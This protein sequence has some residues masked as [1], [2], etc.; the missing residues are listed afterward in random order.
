MAK[1][2][3][4]I[5]DFEEKIIDSP[6]EKAI[7]DYM[8]PYSEYII[9]ERALPK[10][11]DGLKPV[12]RRILY[13]MKE[14]NM[15]PDGPYKKSARVVG[16]CLGKYHPHGDSSIYSAMVNMVQDFKSRCPLVN[17][18]GNFGSIDNDPPAAMRYTEVKLQP[19]SMELMTDLDKDTVKWVRN[20][21]DTLKEPD[22]LPG[23][24]PNLLV[25][26]A[27]G[28]AIGLA[29]KIPPH[30]LT[31]CLDGAIALINN[32][33]MTTRE[34]LNYVKGPDF[35]TG[36]FVIPVTPL[37][38]IYQTGR[39][40]VIIRAKVDI[41]M[42][43]RD[44]Q[45]I[46]ITELP[47]GAVKSELLAKIQDMQLT[48]ANTKDRK[49]VK[50]ENPLAG[51]QEISDESDS[52]GIRAV[53]TVK[54]GEDAVKIVD[55]LF[56]KKI[57]EDSFNYNVTAIANGKPEVLG[58]VSLLEYF[59]EHQ[60]NVVYKRSKFDCKN[61][62]KRAHI[63]EGFVIVL[64]CID[65]VVT[66]IKNS[67]SRTEAKTKLRERFSLSEAQADAILDLK[68]VNLTRMEV[69]KVENELASLHK[70][71]ASLEKIIASN[72]EQL[73]VVKSEL[74]ELRNKY[75]SKRLS[76][77]VDDVKDIEIKAFDVT[78]AISKRGYVCIDMLGR[79]KM[80]SPR[81]FLSADREEPKTSE[82]IIKSMVFVDK[83]VET[84]II[85]SLGNAY[86]TNFSEITEK[87]WDEVGENL[88]DIFVDAP[89]EERCV[90]IINVTE[91]LDKEVF[92]YT[93]QGMVK[94]SSVKDYIVNKRSYQV[95]VLKDNDEVI[96]VEIVKENSYIMFVSS[97]GM[98]LVSE[99]DDYPKQGRKAGGV[100]GMV[101]SPGAVCV[102]AGQVDTE[103]EEVPG[104]LVLVSGDGYAKRVIASGISV[105]KRARK[106]VKVIDVKSVVT[107]ANWVTNPYN[108]VMIDKNDKVCLSS[109]EEIPIDRNRQGKGKTFV[110]GVES[111][112]GIKFLSDIEK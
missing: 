51:I 106:G 112:V 78:N 99:T 86:K 54:K 95:C 88:S 49:G 14:L 59:V 70:L 69:T 50:V 62:K 82:S 3:K 63:L 9:L 97:D 84:I 35:P 109:T 8:M 45:N 24:F 15:K 104:E 71:I 32:P 25:N 39:G 111:I 11:E 16:D 10:V 100:I 79:L 73:N 7:H 28:I 52:H 75:P 89:K 4:I 90:A 77:M 38:E 12:Q 87:R 22:V 68:L 61:A 66:L 56:K 23:K 58:I 65:E 96:G 107:F 91:N 21:D 81:Q 34:M 17:G 5:E 29:T 43:E 18:H 64:P 47:Y 60:R 76:V 37:E 36:G 48:L 55:F 31:E 27:E 92:I 102:F 53:L 57:L 40:K 44:R 46:V 30:N 42:A 98:S 6:L 67:Q 72:K 110:K 101:L 83:G 93:K 20:F 85:G 2:T 13:A 74:T 19:L 103:F 33:K 1:K 26:G 108:F 80:V 41:E 105:F 94:K